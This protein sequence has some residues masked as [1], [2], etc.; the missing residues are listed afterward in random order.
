M[1]VISCQ[2]EHQKTT[3]ANSKRVTIV[4]KQFKAIFDV[5][6]VQKLVII[7]AADD[8]VAGALDQDSLPVQVS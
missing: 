8:F 3:N 2:N 4:R 7:A 1:T 5:R 6:H